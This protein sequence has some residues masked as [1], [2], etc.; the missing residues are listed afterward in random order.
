MI[1]GITE[2]NF[3]SY[4]TLHQ[5]TVSIADMGD[6]TITTQVKIDGAVAP[7]FVG[8]DGKDWTIEFLGEKYIHP[9]RSP[10]AKK[11]NTSISSTIDLTFYHWAIYQLKRYFFV[12]LA[13]VESGTPIVDKYIAPLAVNLSEFATAFANILTYYFPDGEVYVYK[14]NGSYINP[15]LTD[16]DTTT[17]YIE[18]DHTYIWEV[19]QKTY[20]YF[21]CRWSIEKDQNGNYAIKF[22]YPTNA[23]IDHM[24]E[25]GHEGGLVSVERQVQDADIRNQILGRGGEKNLPYMY[26]KNY[27]KFH[28]GSEDSAFRNN[29]IPDPDAIPELENIL[30]SELRDKNF[31]SYV[32]GWKVNTHRQASTEDGWSVTWDATGTQFAESDGTTYQRDEARMATDWAYAKGATDEK[33]DPTEYVKDDESIA[34]YGLL[35]GGLENNE[36]IYPSIQGMS[37]EL[38]CDKGAHDSFSAS[39]V[40]ETLANEVVDVEPVTTDVIKQ[41]G[42]AAWDWQQIEAASEVVTETSPV[43]NTSHS[44]NPYTITVHSAAAS[45]MGVLR[46]SSKPFVIPEGY[47]GNFVQLPELKAVFECRLTA[48]VVVNGSTLYAAAPGNK[49]T[50][51]AMNYRVVAWGVKDYASKEKLKYTTNIPAG[52][53][54]LWAEFEVYDTEYSFPREQNGDIQYSASN[55]AEPNGIHGNSAKIKFSFANVC[56]L[57]NF[58]GLVVANTT[59][60]GLPISASTGPLAAGQTSPMLTL[61]GS[62]FT[63][64]AQGALS[65]DCSAAITPE[66]DGALQKT[67]EIRTLQGELVDNA[68][69]PAGDYRIFIKAYVTNVG[70]KTRNYTVS[71]GPAQVFFL[72][73]D[74][75]WKPTFDIWLKNL[76]VTDRRDYATDEEYVQGVWAPLRSVGGD[77]TVSFLTGNLSGHSDW[78]FKVA[79]IFYDT[80]KEIEVQDEDGY[81]HKVRSEWRLTLVKSDAEADA[82]HQYVPYKDFNAVAGDL[83]VLTN[84]DLPWAY[85][86]AAEARLNEYKEAALDKTS[87]TNP[88]W[89]VAPD[90]VRL[91]ELNLLFGISAGD[92]VWIRDPR[93]TSQVG[94]QLFVQ[95]VTYTWQGQGEMT[96][97]VEFVLTDKVEV[98]MSTVQRID[99]QIAEL[100]SQVRSLSNMER[101]VRAIGDRVYL[102]KDGFN[103][104]SESPTQMARPLTSSDFRHGLIGGAG[105][106]LHTDVDGASILEV[107]K[108]SVRR[109]MNVNNLVINQVTAMGGKEILSAAS[110]QISRVEVTEA[111]YV[112]YFEQH[113]GTIGNLFMKD[114][115]ALSQVY[116]NS[117]EQIKYYKRRITAVGPD[118]IVMSDEDV[119]GAGVPSVGDVVAQFGNYTN[120]ARQFVIIR[121]VIGGGYEQMLS[122]LDS[123]TAT[124]DE[125]YFAG[126]RQDGT[127][128]VLLR[129]SDLL[130][131]R[132]SDEKLLGF[133]RPRLSPRWFVGN[134][135]YDYA[136]WEDGELTIK[137]RI[138]VMDPEGGYTNLTGVAQAV[139]YLQAALPKDT[140]GITT[141]AGGIVLSNIIGVVNGSDLVAGLNSSTLGQDSTHGK[142]MIFAGASDAE[143]V[144]DSP[145]RVYADGAMHS[146]MGT[147]GGWELGIYRIRAIGDNNG[148]IE[149]NS[150][151]ARLIIYN[152]ENNRATQMD[153][154]H[155]GALSDLINTD[156]LISTSELTQVTTSKSI[157]TDQAIHETVSFQSTS[158]LIYRGTLPVSG[159][160]TFKDV[161]FIV[162]L[163]S[164]AAFPIGSV[165]VELYEPTLA[166]VLYSKTVTDLSTIAEH[167]LLVTTNDITTPELEAGQHV[168][169]LRI[170]VDLPS[171]HGLNGRSL[172]ISSSIEKRKYAV[173]GYEQNLTRLFGNG[174]VISQT[175]QDFLA[176]M[177][178]DDGFDIRAESG[179]AGL[180][181]FRSKLRFKVNGVWYTVTRNNSG[182]LILTT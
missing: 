38:P 143:H 29:G 33:F 151:E 68:N 51:R 45:A 126:T 57:Y 82:I 20:E 112:C 12:A 167:Q 132:D 165:L 177:A 2:V 32:Q 114:D 58:D 84:I 1:P 139:S 64:P 23:E 118:Y 27:E 168:I 63:V 111:G 116:D 117:N 13:N 93:F 48:K 9:L 92:K 136:E 56:D 50:Y 30:F 172:V 149:L 155:Y 99:G 75:D 97:D 175:G 18:I 159:T 133:Q 121:D 166:Q 7:S 147:I 28:P 59:P 87:D 49:T 10:Q 69:I 182:Y 26:F 67:I 107:D 91:Q 41:I 83:I 161:N 144:S 65:V 39:H 148:A 66:E 34:E 6:K 134:K 171:G 42:D 124:G 72:T 153:G 141:I 76:F 94:E 152:N 110:M 70:A 17:K 156:N 77:M 46:M 135:N 73:Q 131:L 163:A 24:F 36:D 22:G 115:I 14:K 181:V 127:E 85:V 138:Y 35:Q 157:T 120:N 88:T 137:G 8:T 119:D 31:R 86:Y 100:S 109:E 162:T 81:T 44:S 105:W 145:F 129:D 173:L 98:S 71:M 62:V 4:A 102:R 108:L 37:V 79:D 53:Y 164:T 40:V 140:G 54:F 60:Q 125:Y 52:K 104:V 142:L 55:Y 21:Q 106:G 169:Y 113:G 154:A 122:G 158:D 176:A 101:T 90:K 43:I 130:Q 123:V 78:E 128:R 19:L 3:P 146:T 178:S 170:T 61:S 11:D 15:D 160:L 180:E 150:S 95:S 89:V 96:P 74:D 25:Y 179:D 47:F 103:D 174:L 5:A 80:S 16:Y